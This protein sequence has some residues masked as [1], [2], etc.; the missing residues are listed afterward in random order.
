MTLGPYLSPI[1]SISQI[2]VPDFSEFADCGLWFHWIHRLWSLISL[3]SQ[4]VIP[5]FIEF[6][7]CGPWFHCTH[8][9]WSLISLN[10]QI[11]VTDSIDFTDSLPQCHVEQDA[12]RRS[13]EWS[14]SLN[15]EDCDSANVPAS[16]IE[17]QRCYSFRES[18]STVQWLQWKCFKSAID[19]EKV[20]PR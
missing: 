19:S 17:F 1:L 4:I 7:D 18:S 3:N 10:S 16:Q 6:A 5:D 15:P 20:L 9:L 8:R 11:V 13:K 2:V 14:G 12:W